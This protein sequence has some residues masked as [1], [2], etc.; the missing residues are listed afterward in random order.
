MATSGSQ[1]TPVTTSTA[2][3]PLNEY[4]DPDEV[5]RITHYVSAGVTTTTVYEP[6]ATEKRNT[7]AGTPRWR[8]S[9]AVQVG[10][11]VVVVLA[12]GLIGL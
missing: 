11:G 10:V 4:V 6:I 9:N 5:K 12:V 1:T 3:K 8:P 2:P 7:S